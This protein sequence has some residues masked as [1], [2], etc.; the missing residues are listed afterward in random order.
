MEKD[1]DDTTSDIE[2]KTTHSISKEIF[3]VVVS[4]FASD[5]PSESTFKICAKL[6]QYK[7]IDEICYVGLGKYIRWIRKTTPNKLTNGGIVVNIKFGDNGALI[8]VKCG[9]NRVFQYIF[10]ECIT[11]QKLSYEELVILVAQES[12]ISQNST[13]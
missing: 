6:S 10:D 1:K 4:L 5:V 13:A 7:F 11:F 2:N 9:R 12:L 8:T 3:E